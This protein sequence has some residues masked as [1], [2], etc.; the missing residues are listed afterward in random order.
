MKQR[1]TEP[2]REDVEPLSP[3]PQRGLTGRQAQDRLDRGWG[4]AAPAAVSR[5]SFLETF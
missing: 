1:F 3:D 2:Q 5:R 4:N